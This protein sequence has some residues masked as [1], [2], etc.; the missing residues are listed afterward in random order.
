MANLEHLEILRQGVK[1]WNE[2]RKAN[3]TIKPDFYQSELPGIN[4]SE[5]QLYRAD[6]AFAN[7]TGARFYRANLGGA[8]FAASQLSNAD[9]SKAH[10]D[11]ASFVKAIMVGVDLSET[12]LNRADFSGANITNAVFKGAFLTGAIFREAQ[13][14]LEVNNITGWRKILPDAINLTSADFTNARMG[15]ATFNN[16]DLSEVIGL[17]TVSHYGPSVISIDTLSKSRANIS[18]VFL[19]GCGIPENFITF[20]KSLVNKPIEFYSCF[21]SYSHQDKSF[22][23]R[24]H[25]QLQARGI[26]C[27]MDDHQMLPGHDI[28]EEV[29]R[30]IKL[31]DKVLL[32]ASEHSLTSW[33]VDNEVDT[34]F[35]KERKLMKERNEKVL[36]LIPLNLDGY[37]FS[38]EWKS[39]K[40]QQVRSRLAADFTGWETDNAKFEQQFE[41]VVK[42]LRTDI[43]REA[44]P[45][46]RL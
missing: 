8:G 23:Q 40:A 14:N 5:A 28:Y 35:E 12:E 30:G 32:C 21:I 25:D 46:S 18:E 24:L 22:A 10:L 9:L 3:P 15:W 31:W 34:A 17:E 1:V 7:L 16:V 42:S 4:L 11:G 13:L 43:G 6:F 41:G 37:L 39:G 27:W 19:R 45:I 44:P 29:D 33:W 26:R 38:G 2:W 20:A 36:A